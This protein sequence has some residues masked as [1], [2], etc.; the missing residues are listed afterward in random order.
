MVEVV[1]VRTAIPA[2]ARQGFD[3]LLANTPTKDVE[4]RCT[5]AVNID[6]CQAAIYLWF[7]RK[8]PRG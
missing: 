5:F 1:I 7:D 8:I 2:V 6:T 3:A 4:G